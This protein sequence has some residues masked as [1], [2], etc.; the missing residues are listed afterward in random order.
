MI[1]LNYKF[2]TI[3]ESHHPVVFRSAR[4]PSRCGV[5]MTVLLSAQL[6]MSKR[7]SKQWCCSSMHSQHLLHW[8]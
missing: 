6:R 2:L 4:Q 8:R 3:T 5:W 7:I 1:L